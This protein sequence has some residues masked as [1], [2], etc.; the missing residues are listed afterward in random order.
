MQGNITSSQGAPSVKS[1]AEPNQTP[2]HLFGILTFLFRV[3]PVSPWF[4]AGSS[5]KFLTKSSIVVHQSWDIGAGLTQVLETLALSPWERAAGQVE[6]RDS[7]PAHGTGSPPAMSTNPAGLSQE[8]KLDVQGTT[9]LRPP[10]PE[11]DGTRQDLLHPHRHV[12]PPQPPM[13]EYAA[14]ELSG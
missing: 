5:L 13:A 9:L 10:N 14:P 11:R 6:D 4:R 12:G 3:V 7:P 2:N 1:L 8:A